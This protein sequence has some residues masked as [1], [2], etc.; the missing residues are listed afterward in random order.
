MQP[1]RCCWAPCYPA[2]CSC[3]APTA[4]MTIGSRRSWPS[5]PWSPTH[6]P[7]LIAAHCVHVLPTFLDVSLS[8]VTRAAPRTIELGA[9]MSGGELSYDVMS[10]PTVAAGCHCGISA[11]LLH[12]VCA[13]ARGA[14]VVGCRDGRAGEPTFGCVQPHSDLSG[15]ESLCV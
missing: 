2:S 7:R 3:W 12:C 13:S 9:V 4:S 10:E 15:L 5:A 14:S 11:L 8:S 6:A 1:T